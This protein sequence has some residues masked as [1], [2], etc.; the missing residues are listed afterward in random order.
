MVTAVIIAIFFSFFLRGGRWGEAEVTL[1]VTIMRHRKW[2]LEANIKGGEGSP[3]FML[4]GMS[5]S[6]ST[7]KI[8][9]PTNKLN[10]L[11]CY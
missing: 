9:R 10:Y 3:I 11:V 2:A 6:I 5:A 1:D 7:I 4:A 8:S